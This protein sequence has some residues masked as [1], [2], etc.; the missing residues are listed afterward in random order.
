MSV[1]DK[2]GGFLGGGLGSKIADIVGA[3]IE[4]KSKAELARLELEKAIGDREHEL[5]KVLIAEFNERTIAL[6]GTASD[7]RDLPIVGSVVIFLR[8]AFRPLFA[9][10]VAYLDFVYFIKGMSWGEQQE[11]LLWAVNMLVMGFFFGERA[12]KNVMPLVG[13]VFSKKT[14]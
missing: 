9:Y 2:I 13:Q 5:E 4:D 12:M 11:S 3:R 10:F 1:L 14:V 7:L 6:E 8:G